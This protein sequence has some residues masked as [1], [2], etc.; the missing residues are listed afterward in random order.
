MKQRQAGRETV[1]RIQPKIETER[2][3]VRIIEQ[4]RETETRI[5]IV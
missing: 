3:R 5:Y 2:N 4:Q 1:T